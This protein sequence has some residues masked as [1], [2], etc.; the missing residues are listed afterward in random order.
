MFE[1]DCLGL[2]CPL[3]VVRTQK[4]MKLH[5]EE[6]L[7]VKVDIA[8]AREHITRLAQDK[9]YKVEVTNIGDEIHLKLTPPQK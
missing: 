4:A 6:E 9:G 5:P 2:S 1:V 8:T 7:L 3:P